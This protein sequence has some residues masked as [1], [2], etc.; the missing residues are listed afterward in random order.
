MDDNIER[1]F[2]LLFNEAYLKDEI[3]EFFGDFDESRWSLDAKTEDRFQQYLDGEMT[4]DEYYTNETGFIY[5]SSWNQATNDERTKI[6]TAVKIA[7]K[8]GCKRVLDY[9]SGNGANAVAMA[10][11]GMDVVAVDTCK[12]N[13]DFI[14]AR[15]EKFELKDK[16]TVRNALTKGRYAWKKE[17]PFDMI[18]CTE[19]FEHVDDPEALLADLDSMLNPGGVAVYSWSF[20][21]MPTHINLDKGYQ[22]RHPDNWTTEGFGKIIV[23]RYKYTFEGFCWFNNGLWRK[24]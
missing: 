5:Q 20:M 10:L 7:L 23:D 2:N 16:I 24:P 18:V 3:K 8:E 13:L 9:G 17:E 14:K 4:L 15:A 1:S 6:K 19:V 12:P 21:D 22:A 11:F